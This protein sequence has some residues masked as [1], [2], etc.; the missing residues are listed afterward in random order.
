M[1]DQIQFLRVENAKLDSKYHAATVRIAELESK[2]E[3]SEKI[4]KKLQGACN[5]ACFSLVYVVP[6]HSQVTARV[7]HPGEDYSP[8]VDVQQS[9]FW[10]A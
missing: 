5:T 7:R 1:N 9:T 4:A 6:G 3:E 8:R 2:L 10:Q